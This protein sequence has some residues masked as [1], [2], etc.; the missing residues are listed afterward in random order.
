[1]IS[2]LFIEHINAFAIFIEVFKKIAVPQFG[3][4]ICTFNQFA[5]ASES[6]CANWGSLGEPTG[7]PDFLV[8]GISQN[9]KNSIEQLIFA[10][11][12]LDACGIV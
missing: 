6:A 3:V 9:S 4:S 8:F 2:V 11:F 12:Y 7:F 5:L 10:V 1:V